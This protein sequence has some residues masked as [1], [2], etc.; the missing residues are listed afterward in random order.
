[1]PELL[2]LLPGAPALAAL[3][4]AILGLARRLPSEA[5]VRRVAG[6]GLGLGALGAVGLALGRAT[7]RLPAETV[8]WT[9][10]HVGEDR[11]E[12][13][14]L[15][16]APGLALLLLGALVTV[17]AARFA[18]PYLHREPGFCRFFATLCLFLA[19]LGLLALSND[20]LLTYA[21]WEG[22]GLCSALLIGFFR[23]RPAAATAGTRAYVSGRIGDAGFMLGILLCL[24]WVGSTRWTAIAADA[25]TLSVAQASAIAACFLLAAMAKAGQPPLSGWLLRA[26]EGPT[27]SSALFYG[28]V[29]V[30]GAVLLLLRAGP[31]LDR[32]GPAAT[33]AVLIGAAGAAMGTLISLAQPDVKSA[34]F[35]ASLA[36]VGLMILECGLGLPQLALAHMVAHGLFRGWQILRAPSIISD[37]RR[38][39]VRPVA[40]MLARAHLPY[41]ASL[42]QFWLDELARWALLDPLARLGRELAGID[43]RLV[44]RLTGLPLRR[45]ATGLTT[46]RPELE[47]AAAIEQG[48]GVL[49]RLTQ[50]SATA[51][52]QIEDRLVLR[53]IGQGIPE[54]GGR[55]GAAL[56]RVELLLARPFVLAILVIATL[57]LVW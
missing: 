51:L 52:A 14:A 6:L 36:Q 7:G 49:G 47:D 28:A 44:D 2:L 9:W 50:W 25:G 17:A 53:A 57:I 40:A 19:A 31:L 20:A 37:L 10:L 38:R 11:Y 46:W 42:R 56:T 13:G 8:L 45:A 41:V 27:P 21:G 55:L 54:A 35:A 48:R 22:L 23:E 3:V 29:A 15:L 33:L 32:G 1:M 12:V 43:S 4:L 30:H 34:L 5:L 18:V 24:R 26:V 39:P 16:D